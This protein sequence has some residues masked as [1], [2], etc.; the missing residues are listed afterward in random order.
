MSVGGATALLWKH[1]ECL[2]SPVFHQ[3]KG[4][5]NSN[6]QPSLDVEL[7]SFIKKESVF[8]SGDQ[9]FETYKLERNPQL[10]DQFNT[11]E[12]DEK[13]FEV[14]ELDVSDSTQYSNSPVV[15]S[16]CHS[17]PALK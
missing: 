11:S 13:S 15:S 16:D 12:E 14:Y 17:N 10:E 3:L 2:H 9:K 4:T 5:R 1:L 7:E 6:R 8:D